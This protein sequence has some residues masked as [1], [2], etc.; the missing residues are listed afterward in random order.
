[1]SAEN[2]PIR[3]LQSFPHKI[4]AGRI[5]HIAW[6]QAAGVADAGIDVLVMPGV[7]HKPLPDNVR[8]RPTLARGRARV[9]Y[10][11][12]GRARALALHDRI[13][14]RALPRLADRID[15]VHAWPTGALETLRTA[16]K[17]GIPTVLERPNAHTRFAY[18]AVQQECD[19]LGVQLPPDHEHAYDV[20]VLRREEEEFDAADFLL[21]PSDF[22]AMTH[23]DAGAPA[24][25]LIRHIYG[26]DHQTFHPPAGPRHEGEGLTA[27]FVGVCAVRKGLHFALDAWLA[28][29][30]SETGTFLIAGE[31]LPAY[32]DRLAPQLSHPSV[33]ALGHRTDIPEL[34]R[35]SDMLVL[36]SIEEG[37]GLVCAEAM[38]S[39]SVPLVSTACTDMCVDGE[40]ALVHEVADVEALRGH[41]TALHEDRALLERLR[42]GAARTAPEYTWSEAGR[43]LADAYRAVVE[44]GTRAPVGASA[45]R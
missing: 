38:G 22:V 26:F 11:A 1:M 27:L 37:F 40:N 34:M 14:A 21:C 32:A 39:H 30:A 42:R 2:R 16:R 41:F 12:I 36:P 24:D 4:G 33:H 44:Q 19:R 6:Q 43:R 8:V 20:D 28:S 31:F 17:L 23:A 10:R 13:V 35:G 5:C 9:P 7:V 29:P 15:L 25:R 18:E 3:V 45:A